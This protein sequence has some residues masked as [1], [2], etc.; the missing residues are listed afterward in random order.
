MVPLDALGDGDFKV[1][2]GFS[3]QKHIP[4]YKTQEKRLAKSSLA[5]LAL[6]CQCL[7]TLLVSV[8]LLPVSSVT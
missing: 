7:L 2:G 3:S 1:S 4:Q 5:H 6:L 8:S